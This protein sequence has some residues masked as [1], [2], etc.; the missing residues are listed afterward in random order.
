MFS[1]FAWDTN[2]PSSSRDEVMSLWAEPGSHLEKEEE[3]VGCH[4]QDS[5]PPSPQVSSQS[6][7]TQRT[8]GCLGDEGCSLL[9]S[10]SSCLNNRN[11]LCERPDVYVHAIRLNMLARVRTCITHGGVWWMSDWRPSQVFRMQRLSEI[12][13]LITCPGVTLIIGWVK[14]SWVPDRTLHHGV[15]I[16]DHTL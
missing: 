11:T 15:S 3:E 16:S 1:W 8:D 6:L 9:V 12:G 14:A 10:P 7:I 5:R 13:Q 2:A 4:N